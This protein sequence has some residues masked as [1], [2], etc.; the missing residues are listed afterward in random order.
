MRVLVACEFTGTVRDAFRDRG[1][2]AVSCD[3]KPSEEPGPH[4]QGDV[5]DVLDDGWDLMVAHPPCTYLCN[6]GVRWLHERESR[7][8]KMERAA[9]FFRTLLEAPIP[10]VCIENPV[11]HGYAVEEIGRTYD[12]TIQPYEFG[13]PESKRTCFWL[14]NLPPVE[15]TNVLPEPEDGVWENQTPSGQ[16]KLGPSDSRSEDRAR[17]YE[18]VAEAMAERWG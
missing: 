6:S 15:P 11:P 3:L 8:E 10:K 9:A 18:G 12:Q 4:I 13:H 17:T 2:E 7:W 1:H 14:R 16:N 5:R